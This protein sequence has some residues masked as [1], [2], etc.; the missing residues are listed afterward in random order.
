MYGLLEDDMTVVK[1]LLSAGANVW[2]RGVRKLKVGQFVRSDGA[3]VAVNL[4]K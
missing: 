1:I 4:A 3:R 2:S